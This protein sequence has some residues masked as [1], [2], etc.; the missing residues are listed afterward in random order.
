MTSAVN[1]SLPAD[2]VPAVK[3]DL[4]ANLAA[5]KSEIEALQADVLAQGRFSLS[6]R[7]SATVT[8]AQTDE[9]LYL[10]LQAG[11]TQMQWPN[12]IAAGTTIQGV[13][14][15]GGTVTVA[16][17]SGGTTTFGGP[18]TIPNDKPFSMV[19]SGATKVRVI[20]GG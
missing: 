7:T 18:T 10:V 6:A 17:V 1:A 16:A 9:R 14:E 13:N 15:S 20:V 8:I 2:G 5:A 19:K 3:A 11:V 12:S 4:R